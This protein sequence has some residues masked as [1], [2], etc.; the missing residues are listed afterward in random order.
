MKREPYVAQPPE[1]L[2]S[3]PISM[4]AIL[5]GLARQYDA[6][7][8][9]YVVDVEPSRNSSSL[10]AS[11]TY[12][13]RAVSETT[14]PPLRESPDQIASTGV[15]LF[16]FLMLRHPPRSTLFP[17]TTLFRSMYQGL[18]RATRPGDPQ[19]LAGR[20]EPPGYIDR[21]S[22]RLNS[23]HEWISYAV[24]CVKQKTVQRGTPCR[25]ERPLLLVLSRVSR[26]RA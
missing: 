4:K 21:K 26:L 24:Y 8:A 13:V 9:A 17:Y 2:S 7:R 22:T 19:P 5:Y 1:R 16:F 18:H 12:G 23:S 20:P 11:C 6:R 25:S 14:P 10:S 3:F 15:S